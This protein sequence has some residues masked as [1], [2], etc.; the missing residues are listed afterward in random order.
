MTSYANILG[1][2]IY[3]SY[4]MF[5]VNIGDSFT[6]LV[7]YK[8]INMIIYNNIFSIYDF[9]ESMMSWYCSDIHFV[10]RQELIQLK[11]SQLWWIFQIL[12]YMVNVGN[13]INVMSLWKCIVFALDS[14]SKEYILV[15][16]FLSIHFW[17]CRS[18]AYQIG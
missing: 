11:T 10:I 6:V 9:I 18:Q 8:L 14:Y 17:S 2:H 5:W 12:H 7:D 4:S 3:V 1:V 16:D 13:W 15:E